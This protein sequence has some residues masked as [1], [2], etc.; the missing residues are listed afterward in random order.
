MDTLREVTILSIVLRIALALGIGGI[1]GM[2]RGIRNRP[3]GLRTYMLVCL[4]AALVM[5][6]NQYVFQ[7][8]GISD[9]VRMGAQVVS[10]I[11]FL[12][13]GTIII[14]GKSQV[15]GITTA[16]GLWTAAC[17]GLAVGIGFYEGAIAGGITVLLIMTVLQRMDSFIHAHTK[18][19][20]V[21]IEFDAS[22]RF[23]DFITYTRAMRLDVFDI[24]MHKSKV[25]KDEISNVILT[26]RSQ[27]KLSHNEILG[28]LAAAPGVLFLEQLQ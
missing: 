17:C 26:A 23:V 28:L 3:A 19:I 20:E 25:A 12:G 5:M 15:K 7:V 22:S 10:G 8:Y 18:T 14:T 1:L 27:N 2:E 21:Y 13:A 9:P 4:G 11:G 6:T 16:A 24:Q